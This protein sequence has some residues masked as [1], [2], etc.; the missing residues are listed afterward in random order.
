MIPKKNPKVKNL[1]QKRKKRM[2]IK[3][4]TLYYP[5]RMIIT[6]GLH[7]LKIILIQIYIM[8]MQMII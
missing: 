1:Y 3:L 8:N 7:Y 6:M 2:L 4:Q 5:P